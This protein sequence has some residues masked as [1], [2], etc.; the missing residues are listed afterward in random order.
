MKAGTLR[1]VE[2]LLAEY[3]GVKEFLKNGGITVSGGEPLL[4]LDFLL[5]LFTECKKQGIHTCLDTSGICFTPGDSASMPKYEALMQVTDLVMLDIK[6]I[7]PVEHFALTGQPNRNPL[8]FLDF[9]E[10]K[11]IPTWIRHV[12]VPG[13]TL[14][15]EALLDLGRYLGPYHCIK[16]LDVLPYHTAGIVKYEKLELPYAL[17]GVPAATKEQALWARG[18]I[19]KG[20]KETRLPNPDKSIRMD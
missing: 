11:G 8:A 6:H 18:L 10:E 17:K 7:N 14:Q 1:T 16:A 19:L 15:E 3:N 12:V 13:L 4:Q 2:D 20:M 5:E 9:L